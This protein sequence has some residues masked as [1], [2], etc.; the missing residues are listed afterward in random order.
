[1]QKII[2]SMVFAIF[3]FA[4]ACAP[5]PTATAPTASAT[6]ASTATSPLPTTTATAVVPITKVPPTATATRLATATPE[7]SVALGPHGLLINPISS[8]PQGLQQALNGIFRPVGY[9]EVGP[10][11]R[12]VPGLVIGPADKATA[13]YTS[14]I[15]YDSKRNKIQ[16]VT[17]QSG[18]KSER[19]SGGKMLVCYLTAKPKL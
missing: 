19:Y 13:F 10:Y 7:N 8:L 4:S 2:S 6:V 14:F 17:R 15:S 9:D 3:F 16:L 1:M 18:P 5:A 12:S 11:Y